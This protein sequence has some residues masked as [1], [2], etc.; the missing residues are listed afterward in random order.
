MLY[1]IYYK[2]KLYLS[3]VNSLMFGHVCIYNIINVHIPLLFFIF[4]MTLN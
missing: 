1:S 2:A 3:K 4:Q